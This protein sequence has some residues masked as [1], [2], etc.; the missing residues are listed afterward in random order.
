MPPRRQPAANAATLPA[1]LVEKVASLHQKVTALIQQVAATSH[2]ISNSESNDDIERI[3]DPI[4]D[5]SGDE[6]EGKKI[7]VDSIFDPIYDEY[8][9]EEEDQIV[10]FSPTFNESD[11]EEEEEDQFS[12]DPFFDEIER[13]D[14]CPI[15]DEGTPNSRTNSRQPRENDEAILGNKSC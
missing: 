2:S 1:K 15:F 14:E 4:F 10:N 13:E 8:V 11:G 3:F 9:G 7:T 12:F 5:K 6:G